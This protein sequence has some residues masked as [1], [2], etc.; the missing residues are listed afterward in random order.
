[1]LYKPASMILTIKLEQEFELNA[2]KTFG[3]DRQLLIRYSN[4]TLKLLTLLCL[5]Q[6]IYSVET[7][8]SRTIHK[9]CDKS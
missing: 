8:V 9:K 4:S 7:R 5:C 3:P 2:N 6:N 1:M